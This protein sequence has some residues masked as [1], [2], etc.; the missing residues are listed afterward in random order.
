MYENKNMFYRK[1]MPQVFQLEFI[2]PG[3]GG[4][5]EQ[6]VEAKKLIHIGDYG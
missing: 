6:Q 3:P 5:L 1:I 4:E 2:M